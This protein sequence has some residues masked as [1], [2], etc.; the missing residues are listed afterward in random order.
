MRYLD[1][2]VFMQNTRNYLS[3]DWFMSLCLD[4][5]TSTNA[6]KHFPCFF[7]SF[8]KRGFCITPQQVPWLVTSIFHIQRPM[9][10][11]PFLAIDNHSLP[12]LTIWAGIEP[13]AFRI[14]MEDFIHFTNDTG[15][16][17]H[18]RLSIAAKNINFVK[19]ITC[20][21]L[22]TLTFKTFQTMTKK[23]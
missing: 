2:Y 5:K 13:P 12:V 1:S 18:Q 23:K 19:L 10:S 3:I 7:W 15:W 8:E 6:S 9:L 11:H 14:S 17:L 16:N 4:V 22:Q 20:L 21:Y